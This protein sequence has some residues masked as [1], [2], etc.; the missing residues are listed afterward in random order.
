MIDSSSACIV[1]RRIAWAR[2]TI[3]SRLNGLVT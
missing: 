1:R 2:A 3:S